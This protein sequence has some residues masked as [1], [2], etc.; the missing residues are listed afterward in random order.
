MGNARWLSLSRW[1]GFGQAGAA[2]DNGHSSGCRS[3]VY[4]CSLTQAGQF[5]GQ[6]SPSHRVLPRAESVEMCLEP[7]LPSSEIGEA[8]A[9][10]AG[11]H[12]TPSDLSIEYD[13][14]GCQ[15]EKNGPFVVRYTPILTRY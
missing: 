13:V 10:C 7:K 11:A 5:P 2:W 8:G 15:L 3:S 1:P 9:L 14:Q 12:H 6:I 4:S